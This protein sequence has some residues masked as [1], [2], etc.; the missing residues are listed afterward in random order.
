MGVEPG[1]SG[2]NFLPETV[3]KIKE[4]SEIRKEKGYVF[5]IEVDGGIDDDGIR[6]CMK[7]GVDIL[8]SGMFG[9]F[10][11]EKGLTGD[12]LDCQKLL[13]QTENVENEGGAI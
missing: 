11:R 13:E 5:Q 4:L 2:Q 8:V 7:Y 6:T 1:F 10:K 12:Y 3:R 9:V